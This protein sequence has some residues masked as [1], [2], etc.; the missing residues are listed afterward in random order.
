MYFETQ[1]D[2]FYDELPLAFWRD[3]INAQTAFIQICAILRLDPRID[4]T[5]VQRIRV[6]IWQ[7]YSQPR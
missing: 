5:S 7:V 1:L 4:F 6:R 3:G 2:F